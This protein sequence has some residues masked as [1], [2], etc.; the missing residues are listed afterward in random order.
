MFFELSKILWILAA[1]D[2]IVPAALV[3]GVILLWTPWRRAGRSIATAAVAIFM[4]AGIV[5][6]GTYL[7][8]KLEN[9][10]SLPDPMPER[11]AGVVVL[12]GVLDQRITTVRRQIALNDAAERL[13]EF[14][15]LARRYPEAKLLY[16]GGSGSLWDQTIKEAD[17]LKPLIGELGIDP[18]RVTF[19]N[20]SRNTWENAVLSRELAQPKPDE[21]WLLVTSASHM[22]RAVGCFR[23]AGWTTIVPYPVDFH[24]MPNESFGLTFRPVD[25]LGDWTAAAHAWVGLA[26]YWLTGRT[27]AFFPG[28][29]SRP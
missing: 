13:T 21:I 27:D 14:A 8:A 29:E 26:A 9:R 17:A 12:G 22:P 3:I 18:A 10:F 24:F 25:G 1:P 15:A 11:I 16:S 23:K 6:V 4:A 19:E 5:P 20:Q 28:P 2:R 7:L